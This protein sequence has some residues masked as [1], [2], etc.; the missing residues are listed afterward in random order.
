M[1]GGLDPGKSGA[2]DDALRASEGQVVHRGL[3]RRVDGRQCQEVSTR[4]SYRGMKLIHISIQNCTY[5]T[6]STDHV[7]EG[8]SQ[9]VSRR[10]LVPVSH[11][12][13]KWRREGPEGKR[14][15]GATQER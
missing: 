12:V 9:V 5:Y 2:L 7:V 4:Q 14:S 10:L 3:M 15:K 1:A 13:A 6:K 8:L 11:P